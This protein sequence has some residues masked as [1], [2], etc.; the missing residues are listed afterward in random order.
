MKCRNDCGEDVIVEDLHLR[1][2]PDGDA[3]I[4]KPAYLRTPR[5]PSEEERTRSAIESDKLMT[6]RG[7]ARMRPD[8]KLEHIPA[9]EV[10]IFSGE[11]D[12]SLLTPELL[13]RL[14]AVKRHTDRPIALSES[15]MSNFPD[16]VIQALTRGVREIADIVEMEP[17]PVSLEMVKE[18]IRGLMA[19]PFPMYLTCPKCNARHIDEGEFA[20][21][22]H[23]T[24]SC[25][26][27]GLT[28]RPA[29]GPTVGV[30][31]LPGFKNEAK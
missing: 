26:D 13:A 12:L 24:H 6:G 5:Q 4:C 22:P 19:R 9:A 17:G 15:D 28:W 16:S 8:G 25:Q 1:G 2:T 20:T 31:F 23:A 30:Q 3:W 14:E 29:I 27:C 18:T 11:T 21:K 10:L 7:Y